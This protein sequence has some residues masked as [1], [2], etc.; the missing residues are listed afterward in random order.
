MS[1]EDLNHVPSIPEAKDKPLADAAGESNVLAE[2]GSVESTTA[3]AARCAQA[4][5]DAKWMSHLLE[6]V[7]DEPPFDLE[8][9]LSTEDDSQ[10]GGPEAEAQPA[11]AEPQQADVAVH[12]E[13]QAEPPQSQVTGQ[14][15]AQAAPEAKGALDEPGDTASAGAPPVQPVPAADVQQ[16]TPTSDPQPETPVAPDAASQ[17]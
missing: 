15:E 17:Q 5:F 13:S 10:M 16:A 4:A 14:G 8:V 2:A 1:A 7:A 12:G 11:A 9:D 6:P 3:A